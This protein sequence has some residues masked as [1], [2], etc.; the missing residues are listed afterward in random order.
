VG[1]ATP[2]QRKL[3]SADQPV[4]IYGILYSHDASPCL[5]Q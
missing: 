5:T 1:M 2:V 3:A 4:H